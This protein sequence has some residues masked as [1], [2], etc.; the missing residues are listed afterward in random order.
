MLTAEGSLQDT[1]VYTPELYS[2]LAS[3]SLFD[4]DED[5]A[6]AQEQSLDNPAPVA[7]TSPDA[8]TSINEEVFAQKASL[9]D[10]STLQK[11]A[12]FESLNPLPNKIIEGGGSDKAVNVNTGAEAFDVPEP[13]E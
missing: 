13:R 10:V 7:S 11:D 3:G 5:L 4:A 8:L 9:E 1:D 2:L 12:T 6:P